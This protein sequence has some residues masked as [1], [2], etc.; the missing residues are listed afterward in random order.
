MD[1]R[2]AGGGELATGRKLIYDVAGRRIMA[3]VQSLCAMMPPSPPVRRSNLA[4]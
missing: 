2:V 3:A 1:L 4:R